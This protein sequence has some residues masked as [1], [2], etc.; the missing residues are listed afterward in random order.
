[1]TRVAGSTNENSF[2]KKLRMICATCCLPF[3]ARTFEHYQPFQSTFILVHAIIRGSVYRKEEKTNQSLGKDMARVISTSTRTYERTSTGRASRS[4]RSVNAKSRSRSAHSPR[5]QNNETASIRALREENIFQTGLSLFGLLEKDKEHKDNRKVS[6]RSSSL[7]PFTGVRHS[8]IDDDSDALRLYD[9]EMK[10]KRVFKGVMSKNIES[11]ASDEDFLERGSNSSMQSHLF[12]PSDASTVILPPLPPSETHNIHRKTKRRLQWRVGPLVKKPKAK[13]RRRQLPPQ[14]QN[15]PTGFKAAGSSNADESSVAEK[16][17]RS[18]HTFHSTETVKVGNNNDYDYQPGR[19]FGAGRRARIPEGV[20]SPT[21]T[22][23]TASSSQIGDYDSIDA[24][25]ESVVEAL[26][27]DEHDDIEQPRTIGLFLF[28]RE[29]HMQKEIVGDNRRGGGTSK[30]SGEKHATLNRQM[31]MGLP[32]LGAPSSSFRATAVNNK[33]TSASP[34]RVGTFDRDAESSASGGILWQLAKLQAISEGLMN[35]NE[36]DISS[37]GGSCCKSVASSVDSSVQRIQAERNLRA[38]HRLAAQHLYFGEY[39]E[40]IEVLEEMLRGVQEMYGSHHY[41]VGT[42]LHNL[43]TA[44]MR[45]RRFEMVIQTS[46]SAIDIRRNTLGTLHPDLAVSYS[47][48]G[49][50]H[51][52]LEQHELAVR[53][54][55]KALEIRRKTLPA[56]DNKISRLLNNIGCALFDLGHLKEA[57]HAFNEALEIQ[58]WNL[59]SARGDT[60]LMRVEVEGGEVAVS[61]VLLAIASTLCNLGSIKLRWKQ[62]DEALVHLEEALLIQQ[63]VHGDMHPIVQN[64]KD[65][66]EFIAEQKRKNGSP[67]VASVS[68][69]RVVVENLSRRMEKISLFED[70]KRF[71]SIR[72][73]N[74]FE[75]LSGVMNFDKKE[76]ISFFE[77]MGGSPKLCMQC[78]SST[79]IDEVSLSDLYSCEEGEE[80]VGYDLH[81]I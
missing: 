44:F 24:E 40:A 7:P 79:T 20:S 17:V 60:N 19:F 9:L 22:A 42:V 63:S 73:P 33:L 15:R 23:S 66:I 68:T 56:R 77:D 4:A 64:T 74:P 81:W 6:K 43:A 45:A 59:K 61:R 72:L 18:F 47:Q 30:A 65:T 50:A 38:I 57:T 46:K 25:D 67:G 3:N 26:N 5:H 12:V 80:P 48:M 55:Q 53:A 34:T 52:E 27:T 29:S 51:M 10:K 49:L 71:H 14:H 28:E 76:W 32:P 16:T 70:E 13:N 35:K 75:A 11:P 58:R 41:R 78:S 31:K 69:A 39:D 21:S 62:Y 2:L 54:F 36:G 8:S 37:R 1:M